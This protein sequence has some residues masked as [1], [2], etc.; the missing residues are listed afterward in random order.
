MCLRTFLL[1]M[2]N[3]PPVY[4]LFTRMYVTRV[5]GAVEAQG[6]GQLAQSGMEVS[7]NPK[8]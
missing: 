6:G 7:L 8:G 2:H 1:L 3:D 5:G 4:W